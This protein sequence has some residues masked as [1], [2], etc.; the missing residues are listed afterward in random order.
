MLMVTGALASGNLLQLS[1]IQTST[2]TNGQW[3]CLFFKH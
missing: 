2:G 3:Q 1:D